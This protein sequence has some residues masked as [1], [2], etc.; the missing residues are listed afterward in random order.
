MD[1]LYGSGQKDRA[2]EKK[3]RRRRAPWR[4]TLWRDPNTSTAHQTGVGRARRCLWKWKTA[5]GTIWVIGN[6][7]TRFSHIWTSPKSSFAQLENGFS[8][9]F[10]FLPSFLA[11][12]GGRAASSMRRVSLWNLSRSSSSFSFF[13]MRFHFLDI[14]DSSNRVYTDKLPLLGIP[15]REVFMLRQ[16]SR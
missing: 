10:V 14:N 4:Q 7:F 13:V 3:N 8:S 12:V 1:G 11:P 5:V 16:Q 6:K 2:K 9:S 15:S